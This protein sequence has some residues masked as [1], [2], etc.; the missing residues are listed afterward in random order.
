VSE[1]ERQ[2]ADNLDDFDR[3]E[4]IARLRIAVEPVRILKNKAPQRSRYVDKL[5]R[6]LETWRAAGRQPT[7]E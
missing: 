6:E 1:R 4:L 2:P 7:A 5:K 3:E